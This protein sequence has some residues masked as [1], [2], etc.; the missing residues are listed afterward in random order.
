MVTDEDEAERLIRM[1]Q[2]LDASLPAT[3][4]THEALQKAALA[5][6]LAFLYRLRSRVEEMYAGISE[7]L[8]EAQKSHLRSLGIK[9][10]DEE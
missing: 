3:S 9:P 8:T 5:L 7:P 1:L 4:P 6:R 10:I 2:V